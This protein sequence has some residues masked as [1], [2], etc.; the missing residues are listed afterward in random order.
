[1]PK[2]TKKYKGGGGQIVHSGGRP[3]CPPTGAVKLSTHNN[4]ESNKEIYCPNSSS[5]YINF[6]SVKIDDILITKKDKE[7]I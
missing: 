5:P 7:K 3:N 4:K 6:S 2:T 1:M